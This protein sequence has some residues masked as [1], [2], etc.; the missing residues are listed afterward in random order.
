MK[1][2]LLRLKVNGYIT[3]QMRKVKNYYFSVTDYIPSQTLRGAILA[4]YYYQKGKIDYSF[5]VSPS[6]PVGVAPSHYFS[7]AEGRKSS[8]FVEEKEILKRKSEEIEKKK[9]EALRLEKEEAKPKIGTLIKLSEKS[10]KYYKYHSYHPETIVLTHVAIDKKTASN[11]HGMLFAYEYKKFETMWA[12]ASPSSEVFDIVKEIRVGRGK[13]RGSSRVTVEKV[14]E[15][16]LHE[17]EGLSYCLSPVVPK[18]FDKKFFS[19][20]III[21]DEGMYSG[22]FTTDKMAGEKPVFKTLKEGSLIYVEEKKD[23][24]KLFTAGLN[25]VFRIDDLGSLLEMV[26]V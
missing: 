9:E 13:S 17:P 8:S 7:P 2:V 3:T 20:K 19:T 15:V 23:F 4:E 10:D 11:Y 16:E 24:E 22:W 14:K 12:L 21:G 6:Y 26:R 18:L 1:F 5:Y 25:F